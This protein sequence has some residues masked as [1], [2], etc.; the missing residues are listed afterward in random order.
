[1]L[2]VNRPLYFAQKR[3]LCYKRMPKALHGSQITWEMALFSATMIPVQ[4]KT[5]R[6]VTPRPVYWQAGIDLRLKGLLVIHS[7]TVG[8]LQNINLFS[9]YLSH[10]EGECVGPGVEA[11]EHTDGRKEPTADLYHQQ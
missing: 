6:R 3:N 8:Y 10:H 4:F 1:M 2:H 11:D 5:K 7:F 9:T